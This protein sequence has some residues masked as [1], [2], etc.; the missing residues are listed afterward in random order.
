[1]MSPR[2][3]FEDHRAGLIVQGRSVTSQNLV[4]LPTK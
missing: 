3:R 2:R 4:N 1:M